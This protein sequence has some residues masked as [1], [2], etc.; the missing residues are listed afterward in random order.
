MTYITLTLH[1]IQR[2]PLI[3]SALGLCALVFDGATTS[4]DRILKAPSHSS[5]AKCFLQ[6][7]KVQAQTTSGGAV[8]AEKIVQRAPFV[9]TGLRVGNKA[10][11][12]PAA[13]QAFGKSCHD[14]PQS[15]LLEQ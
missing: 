13:R 15:G 5:R 14:P 11:Q 9:G 6:C 10:P 4:D 7:R 2:F 12:R 8:S 1:Q 3:A